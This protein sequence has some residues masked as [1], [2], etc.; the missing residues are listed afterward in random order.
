MRLRICVRKGLGKKKKDQ[1]YCEE[2]FRWGP[3]SGGQ[4]GMCRCKWA[5]GKNGLDDSWQKL[6]FKKADGVIIRKGYRVKGELKY[7]KLPRFYFILIRKIKKI[8]IQK[9][10]FPFTQ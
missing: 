5:G 6:D 3:R 10:K 1:C 4:V 2:E 8:Q 7:Y 9:I